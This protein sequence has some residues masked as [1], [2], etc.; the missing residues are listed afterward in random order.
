MYIFGKNVAKETLEN[1]K[2]V[3]KAFV[4]KDFS[5]KNIISM[6]N[7]RHIDKAKRV[8]MMPDVIKLDAF[9]DE[10]KDGPLALGMHKR[11]SFHDIVTVKDCHIV[12]GD[13]RMIL[14]EV[15]AFFQEKGLPYYHRMRH[16]GILRHLLVRGC[17]N[18]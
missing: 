6:L 17:Q 15:L 8:P 10:Y 3:L 7:E 16:D 9:G 12:D 13:Y 4:S 5:D 2:M 18:R 11:G 1:N 14:N